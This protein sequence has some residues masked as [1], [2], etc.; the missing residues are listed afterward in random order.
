MKYMEIIISMSV[1]ILMVAFVGYHT[2][3]T[4]RKFFSPLFNELEVIKKIENIRSD[5]YILK[6]TS[7]NLYLIEYSDYTCVYCALVRGYIKNLQE[8]YKEL[9]VVYRHYYPLQRSGS[10][11][12]AT[13]SDCVHSVYGVDK[14]WEYTNLIY[15][16]QRE[17]NTDKLINETLTTIKVD[18]EK[19]NQC[20]VETKERVEN[21]IKTQTIQ[22]QRLGAAG[23]PYILLVKNGEIVVSTYGVGEEE[24]R[25]RL[26]RGLNK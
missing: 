18:A 1:A 17:L 22:L 14:F 5:E 3:S 13:T 16:N 9:N 8:E 19:I 26:I 23:T 15:L 20:L 21:E 4:F 24:F 12:L 10:I 11:Q 7:D 2:E 6:G 25:K